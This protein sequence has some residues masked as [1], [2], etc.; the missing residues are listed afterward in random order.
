MTNPDTLH[1]TQLPVTVLGLGAMGT[2]VS[3]TLQA[4]GHPTTVWNRTAS[5][6]Q[7]LAGTGAVI[8][9]NAAAAVAASELI[10]TILRDHRSTIEL[11]ESLP[12]GALA[13][14]TVVVLASSTPAEA[15]RTQAWAEGRGVDVL[16]GAI[17]VPTPVIGTSEAL[18]LYAGRDELPEDVRG[19]LEVF[20]PNSVLVGEDPGLAALLDTAMLEI[21]FAGMT[22]FLHAS[23]M[24]TAGGLRAADFV[25]WAHSM[26]GLLTSTAGPLAAAVDSGE[27]PGTEDTIAMERA[28]LEHIVATSD[29]AG[30][31]SRLPEL[32][33]DLAE[34]AVARGHGDDSWS[35][36]VEILRQPTGA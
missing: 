9:P 15:R 14:R 11:L 21:F 26:F 17:M 7:A 6:A 33:H 1:S 4:A 12:A 22:S 18:V 10:L 20:A 3:R 35:R 16:I 36:V 30:L 24:V 32:M 13:G 27:H 23:A 19:T 8:A 31:D 2:A 25:P 34:R 28:S 29:E 5:K